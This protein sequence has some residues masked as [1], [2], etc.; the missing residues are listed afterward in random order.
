MKRKVLSIDGGGIKGVFPAAFLATIEEMIDD[1]VADYFD[2]IVGTSTGG[3]I[4]LGMGLGWAA[5]DVLAFYERL[6]PKIFKRS[7][8]AR[9]PVLK[10]F[11]HFVLAKYSSEP[12]KAALKSEFKE[13]KLGESS[14]R[15]VIPSL[16]L[17]NGKVH[18]YKTA[19]LPRFR[20]DYKEKAAD[21]ALATAAAP[22]YFPAHQSSVGLPLVDGGVWANNPA[23]VAAVEAIAILDWP[24][25]S[26]H[27]LSISC[28]T[29]PLNIKYGRHWSLGRGYWAMRITDLFMSAQSSSALGMAKHLLGQENVYRVDVSVPRGRYSMD[30]T[31]EISSLRG[32]GHATARQELNQISDIFFSDKAEPFEPF[33][34]LHA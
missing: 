13:R 24:R 18:L 10:E 5:S 26:V 14:T 22:T 29:E 21:V 20:L 9:I 31:R 3:I 17:E 6:G 8:L 25:D 15:L 7:L 16:N 28:T 27:M 30:S 1:R 4:A 23:A 33:H 2:L 32:L 19:H 11:P 12:L 34:T